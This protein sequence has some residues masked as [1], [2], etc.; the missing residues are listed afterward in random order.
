VPPSFPSPQ[1]DPPLYLGRYPALGDL[2]ESANGNQV[3]A[4]LARSCATFLLR[5][6]PNTLTRDN[7]VEGAAN[8]APKAATVDDY[9]RIGLD[10]KRISRPGL[11]A[12]AWRQ[13]PDYSLTPPSN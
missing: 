8:Q 1:L 13:G 11:R 9:R 12:D 3:E 6:P 4:N 7:I 10:P 2:T 5:Q